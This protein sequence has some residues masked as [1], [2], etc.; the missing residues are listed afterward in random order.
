MKS[1]EGLYRMEADDSRASGEPA[2]SRR[3]EVGVIS[4]DAAISGHSHIPYSWYIF[5]NFQ[6][7]TYFDLGLGVTVAFL[8]FLC[9]R[10]NRSIIRKPGSMQL[11]VG[12]ASAHIGSTLHITDRLSLLNIQLGRQ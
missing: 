3:L 6:M 5:A 2:Y 11:G 8:G 12:S 10:L 7:A 1:V 4:L 9:F